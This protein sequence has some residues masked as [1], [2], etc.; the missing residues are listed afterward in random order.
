MRHLNI[1]IIILTTAVFYSCTDFLDEEPKSESSPGTY[2]NNDAEAQIGV[3]A[4]YSTLKNNFVTG[5]DIKYVP[6]DLIK[7]PSWSME[8]GLGDYTFS[9]NNSRLQKMWKNH[10]LAI[11]DCNA[12]IDAIDAKRDL[13]PSADRFI[14]EAQGVRAFLYFD[15][16]RWYGDVPLILHPASSPSSE[17]LNV[18][19]AEKAVIF[20]QILD[21][22]AFAAE[23]APNKNEDNGYQY[24]RFSKDAAWALLAKV[25]LYIASITQR[26]NTVI[27][28]DA[29]TNFTK[30]I[31]AAKKVIDNGNYKLTS[32]YPDVFDYQT[33]T[34]A[35]EEVIFASTRLTGDETGGWTGMIF[36]ITGD[37]NNGGAWG[38]ASSTDFHRSIY[39]DSDS[40]R[41][42]WNCPRV[43]V[44]SDGSLKGWDY[45]QYYQDL[46][47]AK[48]KTDGMVFSIG[49]F[50]RYPVADPA[51]YNYQNFGMDEPLIRFS[52]VL[53]IY[54]EAYNEIHNGPGAYTPSSGLTLDGS[55]INSAYDAVNVVRKRA[56]IAN[57]GP[58]HEDI[59][60]RNYNYDEQDNVDNCVPDWK[61]GFYGIYS[62]GVD[63]YTY[64]S[65]SSD[66]NAFREEIL[67]E[68]AREFVA[69]T[70]DR[71]CDLTRR[72]M[73]VEKLRDVRTTVVPYLGKAE[74]GLSAPSYPENVTVTH[75]LLPIPLSEIDSNNKLTQNP[76]Y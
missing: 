48:E 2:Y 60:P 52:D 65:Y 5:Y 15:L 36:G 40:I 58:V 12:T 1:F 51:S 49:K 18:A 39:S 35:H 28:D 64:R 10:Y 70:T 53:L 67:W 3:N 45:P 71:W 41:R 37:I 76:G 17:E 19:R 43:S 73:L 69:E 55:N 61:P 13:I 44:K 25:H 57:I 32:Y 75:Q 9:S 46:D 68:R 29:A 16:V 66:Y 33:E 42:L 50:R 63:N 54:A 6:T 38:M 74:R 20:K 21:D 7:K 23:N 24:G 22:L 72:G 59:L 31:E 56:R 47:P 8:E 27:I 4:I 62:S 26:D 30:A 34:K 14:A 11:K